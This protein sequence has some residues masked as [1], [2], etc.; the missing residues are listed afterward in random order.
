MAEPITIYLHD[1]LGGAR[2][3]IEVLE[4]MLKHQ[5]DF[6]FRQFA[7]P[8][9]V[10]IKADE[11]TLQSIAEKIGAGAG[12][13]KQVG[14]WLL[15]KVSRLKLGHTDSADFEMFES[16]EFLAMGILGKEHLWK[17]LRAVSEVDPRLREYD[18]EELIQRA[19]EQHKTVE[20]RKLDLARL[21]FTPRG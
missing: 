17:S 11:D 6:Q 14:G 19:E 5:G 13:S 21:V 16:L 9:L 18:F 1:H 2:T 15:E 3:A 20:N 10:E 12:V 4:A 8:L 7:D